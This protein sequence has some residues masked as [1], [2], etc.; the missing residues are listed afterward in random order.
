MHGLTQL[1]IPRVNLLQKFFLVSNDGSM[2]T[3]G[4]ISKTNPIPQAIS[5]RFMLAI[6]AKQ[7]KLSM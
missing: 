3:I 2:V 7:K 6:F 1:G 5:N 4:M